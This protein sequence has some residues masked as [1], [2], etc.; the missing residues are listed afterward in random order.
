MHLGPLDSFHHTQNL[1]A[2]GAECY[3]ESEMRIFISETGFQ[4][5]SIRAYGIGLKFDCIDR[6]NWR[7]HSGLAKLVWSTASSN[8]F[9]L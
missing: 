4:I 3:S 5:A 6:V 1:P 9:V 7:D 2:P 8:H